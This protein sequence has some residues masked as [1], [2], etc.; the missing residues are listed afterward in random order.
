M[1]DSTLC[2]Q[3]LQIQCEVR[4]QKHQ[5]VLINYTFIDINVIILILGYHLNQIRSQHILVFQ[6]K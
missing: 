2:I 4:K 5:R 1:T 6:L 3:I